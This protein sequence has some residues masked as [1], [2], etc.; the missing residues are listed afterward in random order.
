[1]HRRGSSLAEIGTGRLGFGDALGED[2]GVFVLL[3]YVRKSWIE[4]EGK[5]IQQH[6]WFAQSYGASVQCDGA[7][8]EDVVG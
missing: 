3:I 5:D 8:A 4:L 1:V 7:C 6:P 2:G